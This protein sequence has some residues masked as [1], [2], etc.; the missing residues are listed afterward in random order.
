MQPTRGKPMQDHVF[1][2][3]TEQSYLAKVT[4]VHD[5]FPYIIP[6]CPRCNNDESME[7]KV[8]FYEVV[9]PT[10]THIYRV[11]ECADCHANAA[12]AQAQEHGEQ[13][14]RWFDSMK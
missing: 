14:P 2:V 3:T 6:K 7:C 1:V 9:S 5:H 10:V 8:N 12:V 4:W 11:F 13:L